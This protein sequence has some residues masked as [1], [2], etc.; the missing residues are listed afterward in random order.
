MWPH[1]QPMT[2]KP[3]LAIAVIAAIVLV[4][5]GLIAAYASGTKSRGSDATTLPAC[6]TE[7]SGPNPCYWDATKHGG[8]T[9]FI[10]FDGVVY[11]AGDKID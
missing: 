11:L 9:S 6:V 8:G 4:A 3:K 1:T 5:G 2:L 7:D 10:I